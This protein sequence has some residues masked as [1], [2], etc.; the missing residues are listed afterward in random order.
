MP[1]EPR[2]F[3]AVKNLFRTGWFVM[4]RKTGRKVTKIN[5]SQHE[6]RGLARRLNNRHD[7]WKK[8]KK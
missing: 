3:T 1:W 6:A 2:R 4:D 5:Q 7:P 8:D